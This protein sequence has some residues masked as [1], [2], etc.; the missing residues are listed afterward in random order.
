MSFGSIHGGA[1]NN[2]I[3]EF[4]EMTGTVRTFNPEVRA[5]MPE[6]MRK[7]VEEIASAYGTEAELV[8]REGYRR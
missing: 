5:E 8:Y 1:A 7:L 4:V 2:V 6:M 3:P